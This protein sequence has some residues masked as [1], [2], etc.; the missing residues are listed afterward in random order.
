MSPEPI[1][2]RLYLAAVQEIARESLP[3]DPGPVLLRAAV[4]QVL[5]DPERQREAFRR[6]RANMLVEDTRCQT[7]THP[8]TRPAPLPQR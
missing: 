5:R 2:H 1:P 4:D 7:R 8:A 3:G 6:A